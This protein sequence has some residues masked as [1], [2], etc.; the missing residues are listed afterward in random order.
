MA[1]NIEDLWVWL[2]HFGNLVQM[3]LLYLL[4]F[5]SSIAL[6]SEDACDSTTNVKNLGDVAQRIA[7]EFL[8]LTSLSLPL[9]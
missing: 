9:P 6:G 1:I 4:V 5:I 7:C 8:L 2:A 3:H